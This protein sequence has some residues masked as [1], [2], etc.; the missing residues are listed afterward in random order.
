MPSACERLTAA[1]A[2]LPV[3]AAEADL[4]RAIARAACTEL[5][6]PWSVVCTAVPEG[7]WT[8]AAWWPAGAPPGA[9]APGPSPVPAAA[10]SLAL[11]PAPGLEPA[12][13]LAVGPAPDP[14]LVEAFA[15]V[16]GRLLAEARARAGLARLAG[17]LTRQVQAAEER[18]RSLA[19]RMEDL[20]RELDSTQRR[21]LVL[22]ERHRIAQDLHDRAAQTLFLIGLK[23]DW[24]LARAAPDWPLR[25]ELERL[26]ELAA[27]GAA[28][29][30]EAI[31]ALRAPELAEGG[32]VGG[33]RQLVGRVEQEGMAAD[34]TIT[35]R[36]AALAPEVEDALFKVAQE[37]LTNACK[38]SGGSGVLVSLRF[39]PGAVTLVVQDDGA[40]LPP[41]ASLNDPRRLGLRGMR[42]RISALGGTLAL[43]SGDEG[44]LLVRAEVPVK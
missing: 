38:H 31:Y 11:R 12:A 7:G 6:C 2:G 29:T 26:K 1:L 36:P 13:L 5:G 21:Q 32:L 33:L 25:A 30:R 9:P 20:H 15:A 34:L 44:G 22:G 27:L 4:L 39:A 24:L 41:G 8:P 28:Q 14:G 17:D 3:A 16:A 19:L 10:H 35:G 43:M 37:A 18:H 40:G 42:E 23:A